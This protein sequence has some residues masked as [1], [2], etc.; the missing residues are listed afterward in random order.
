MTY[1]PSQHKLGCVRSSSCRTEHPSI[2]RAIYK[3]TDDLYQRIPPGSDIG[4]SPRT[5]LRVSGASVSRIYLLIL[6]TLRLTEKEQALMDVYE[7]ILAVVPGLKEQVK[8][9]HLNDPS[10]ILELATFVC[11]QCH[12]L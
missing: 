10:G 6:R 3:H 9:T 8:W 5:P 11:S 12:S 2:C 7:K 1:L 4:D